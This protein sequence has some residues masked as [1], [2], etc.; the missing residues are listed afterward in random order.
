M[1]LDRMETIRYSWNTDNRT[2]GFD[3]VFVTGTQGHPFSFGER[4]GG[5][6]VEIRDFLMGAMPVTQA[7]WAHVMSADARLA[8]HQ[9]LHSPV[10]NVSWDEITRSGGFLDR[11]NKGPVR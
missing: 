11:I 4:V 2:H 9:E 10:E 5:R 8:A 1:R 6:S 3:L 7:L